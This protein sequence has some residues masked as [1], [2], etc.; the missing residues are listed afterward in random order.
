MKAYNKC[1]V[2]K[3]FFVLGMMMIS[4]CGATFGS[5]LENGI[6]VRIEEPFDN[7]DLVG[8]PLVKGWVVSPNEILRVELLLDGE[9]YGLLPCSEKRLDIESD[10]GQ[11]G[12]VSGFSSLIDTN[13]ISTGFHILTVRALDIHNNYNEA[14]IYVNTNEL[15]DASLEPINL[16]NAQ[17]NGKSYDLIVEW[18][19]SLK[20]YAIREIMPNINSFFKENKSPLSS[21]AALSK[22]TIQSVAGYSSTYLVTINL[23]AGAQVNP[24]LASSPLNA[25]KNGCRGWVNTFKE[26]TVKEFTALS[27][28]NTSSVVISGSFHN[29]IGS[30]AF[31]LRVKGWIATYG[32]ECRTEAGA[33]SL[34]M[35]TIRN[36]E[37]RAYISPFDLKSFNSSTIA[38]NVVVGLSI[39]FNKSSTSKIGRN[40]VGVKNPY[41]GGYGTIV[42]VV[43]SGLLSADAK[44]ILMNN[45]CTTDRMMQLDGSTIAQLSRKVNS[46][47]SHL[48]TYSRQM[49]QVFVV[50]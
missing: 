7:V 19:D 40:F 34:M 10:F 11:F 37:K 30:P 15:S 33:N 29:D 35:L 38:P 27:T 2:F 49:P 23:S 21:S 5:S 48:I 3:W 6:I 45:G 47:W 4:L 18:N 32:Y 16:E 13:K 46:T 8:F 22:Y 26:L 50:Y 28:I 24:A 36:S 1:H 42:F 41:N 44:K 31:P 9:F 39:N 14:Q 25:G 20:Q 17:I 12:N 43:S